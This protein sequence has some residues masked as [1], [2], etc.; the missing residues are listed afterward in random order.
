MKLGNF[1]RIISND[2]PETNRDLVEQLGKSLNDGIEQLYFA[3]NN[4][5]TFSDNFAATVK[6]VE[7]TVG[8]NGN[9]INRTSILLN[10][11]N[12]VI[13]NI[14]ISAVNKSN[15]TLYPTSSPFISFTQDGKTLYIDNITGL[16]ANNRYL[17]KIIAL[18]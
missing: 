14:V 5:L 6:E 15:A 4:K 8:A 9:P 1:K 3:N 11:T 12:V 10:N 16:Q 17:V 13:G 2:Y 18:N 7:I